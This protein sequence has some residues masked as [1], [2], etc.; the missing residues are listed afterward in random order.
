MI[1]DVAL[2]IVLN[3]ITCY[4]MFEC[5][6]AHPTRFRGDWIRGAITF[7]IFATGAVMLGYYSARWVID[8]LGG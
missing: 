1:S 7:L 5:I 2:Y 3:M 6:L 4:L 8:N